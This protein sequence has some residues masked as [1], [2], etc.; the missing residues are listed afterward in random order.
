VALPRGARPVTGDEVE[1]PPDRRLT[2]QLAAS[3]GKPRGDKILIE[4]KNDVRARLGSSTDDADA[5]I[6]A[7]HQREAAIAR[8]QV[9]RARGGGETIIR[10][11]GCGEVLAPQAFA[12][13]II[14]RRCRQAVSNRRV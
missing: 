9:G 7:W 6:L 8:R 10:V 3:T 12:L 13:C 11:V 2:A 5:V 14:S 4:S 1:L